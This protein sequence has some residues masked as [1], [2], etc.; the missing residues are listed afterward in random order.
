MRRARA[1]KTNS[2]IAGDSRLVE[3]TS[4]IDDYRRDRQLLE[5][6]GQPLELGP[7][8][9]QNDRV[10]IP[11]SLRQRAAILDAI[12]AEYSSRGWLRHRVV[13]DHLRA[14]IPQLS[15]HAQRR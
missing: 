4:P 11:D 15:N 3:R 13:R 5:H 8:G 14:S 2:F 10:N 6:L 12:I 1:R 7:R 9:E